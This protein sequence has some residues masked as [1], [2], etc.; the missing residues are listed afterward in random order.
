M[1]PAEQ[2]VRCV[3]VSTITRERNDLQPRYLACWLMLAK[4]SSKVTVIGQSVRSREE[5]VDF[6]PYTQVMRGNT[7]TIAATEHVTE[8]ETVNK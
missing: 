5:S 8:T 3:C 4:S 2:S 6:Y 7:R 1:A